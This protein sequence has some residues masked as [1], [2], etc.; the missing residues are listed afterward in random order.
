LY[1]RL[2]GIDVQVPPLRARREDIGELARYFLE[3]HRTVCDLQL[4]TAAADALLVYDWPGKV[5]EL[6]HRSY[7]FFFPPLTFTALSEVTPAALAAAQRACI[8]LRIFSRA[9]LD[10][11]RRL[12][13]G[14]AAG[15]VTAL[16]VVPLVICANNP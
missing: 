4:S 7:R 10:I 1:Y 11:V 9:S 5:H 13:P 12:R 6:E 15:A 16:A 3:R 14:F 2:H 8:D